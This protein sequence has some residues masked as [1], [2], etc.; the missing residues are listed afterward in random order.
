LIKLI[1]REYTRGTKISREQVD[2]IV[3]GSYNKQNDKE[4]DEDDYDYD[5]G[6]I[7]KAKEREVD[8]GE[9]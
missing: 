6:L 7:V 4:E 8:I 3:Y 9:K 1:I 5:E 2:R